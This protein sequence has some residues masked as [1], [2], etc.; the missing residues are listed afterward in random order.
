MKR[1]RYSFMWL[2]ILL[3]VPLVAELAPVRAEA[4]TSGRPVLGGHDF[5]ETVGVPSPFVRTFIRNRLGAGKALDIAP[6]LGEING[7]PITGLKGD[8]IFAILDFEYQYAIKSWIGARVRVLGAG[9][10]GSNTGSLL[11]QG[12][13]MTTGFE[14]GWLVRLHES[15]RTALSMDLGLTDR[16]FTSVN[17]VRFIEDIIE[18]NQASLTRKTPSARASIGA[19]FAWS[20]SPLMGVLANVQTGYGESVERSKDDVWFFKL[21]TVLDFDLRTQMSAPLGV[22]VGFSYDTFP[23]LG[24]DIAQ[25]VN[26]FFFRFSYLGRSDFLFSVDL[27]YDRIPLTEGRETLKGNSITINMRY[28]I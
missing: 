21:G 24:G 16:G 8:L 20:V 22:A 15:R 26:S 12:V 25:G 14:F 18:G 7:Q 6:S 5:T 17:L 3:L 23:E 9:R 1:D 13:T 28:Y 11:T 19:R 27:S 10:L 2:L 4:Q